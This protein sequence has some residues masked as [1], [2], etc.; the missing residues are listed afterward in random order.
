M[1]SGPLH[2]R[3]NELAVLRT[4]FDGAR[5]GESA[6]LVVHGE[7]GIGKTA[8]VRS[9]LARLGDGVRVEHAVGVESE[10]ELPY[11]GLHLL[12]VGLLDRVGGLPEPQ[13][14]ALEVALGLRSGPAPGPFLIGLAVLGLLSETAADGPLCCVVDDAQWLDEASRTVLA[15]AARRLQSEGV[16]LLF[17]MRTVD[18]PFTRLPELTLTGLAEPDAERLLAQ[19]LVGPI[20]DRIRA[21]I[22]AEAKGNPLALR[23]LPLVRAPADLAGGFTM[24]GP[25]SLATR[26]EDS[27]LS[28]L[29][30]LAPDA[31]SVML[32]AAADPTGDAQLLRRAM[33]SLD[34]DAGAVEAVE[35]TGDLVIGERVE[36]RHPLVRSGVYRTALPAD[37][38]RAHATLASATI[39]ERDPDRRA[40]HRGHAAVEPDE[41]VA[42]ELEGSSVRARGRGGVSAAAAFL[43][44]AAAL[45]P[46][47]AG[48]ARRLLAA[49]QA[50]LD[51]GAPEA[52]QALLDDVPG[53]AL[54]HRGSALAALL[55]AQ[56]GFARRRTPEIA[57]DI[58]AAARQLAGVDPELRRNAHYSALRVAIAQ[59]G[60]PGDGVDDGPGVDGYPWRDICQEV[61]DATDPHSTHPVDV[62]LRGQALIGVG[63]RARAV[64]VLH[65][66]LAG[67]L[68]AP[69][70][71]IPPQS[72]GLEAIS[73]ADVWDMRLLMALC[74]RQI[75]AARAEGLLTAL[76][77][78]LSYAGA[79]CASLG[80]LD[81][82]ER[83]TDEIAVIGEAIG[84]TF[85]PHVRVQLAAWRGDTAEVARH[86]AV[87]R[88]G[89]AATG[90]GAPLST[91]HYAEAIL[92]NGL[93]RH[94][95]AVRVGS[96]ELGH[97][98]Q[99][100]FTSRIAFELVEAAVRVRERAL[101][102]RALT[103]LTALTEPVGG[104]W[105]LGTLA[106]ARALTAGPTDAEE[107]HREAIDRLGSAEMV[108]FEARAR[109]AYGEWLRRQRRRVDAREQLR[110]A[111]DV[112]SGRGAAGFA[113]RA[114]RE[115][116]A[117]GETAR[118]RTEAP[119]TALTTQ[120]AN[121]ARLVAEGLTNREIATRLFVS[122]RTV[123]YHLRKVF[124]KRG[125]R[126]RKE[127]TTAPSLDPH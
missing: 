100:T 127:L 114:G 56:A 25:V 113:A 55:R 32:L 16:V 104:D 8:L 108:I 115:L 118:V 48:R 83:F 97:V 81:D 18:A 101:A 96:L 52:A 68:T 57:R 98:R 90:D 6:T 38:R 27:L 14:D 93:G 7:A 76:P 94:E 34:V 122:D 19:Q 74:E 116:E 30:G 103:E 20:D 79:A 22:L 88:Q 123:E 42:A 111:H 10:M 50:K 63:A 82:A 99:V 1:V 125:I 95:D 62:L 126:S 15:F 70:D 43:E 13:R 28:R 124:L 51:A 72:I 33:R 77:V 26:I 71:L 4:L 109:L 47:P 11:A 23:E 102:D 121:V 120:E 5:R 17:V 110:A 24:G 69:V 60:R 89:A 107:H 44:R 61:L 91:A 73:A 46:D 87:L 37:R 106:A 58:L 86:A 45:S 119:S 67:L 64:P 31:R 9:A 53:P 117:T 80:R 40:W 65:R 75:A 54:D 66:A 78:M 35:R 3:S 12:L 84:Y 2:G 112:L 21:R 59:G 85:P 92:A 29:D 41:S 105:A 49:A 39:A 36:F